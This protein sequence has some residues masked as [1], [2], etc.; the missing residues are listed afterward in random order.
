MSHQVYPVLSK[1]KGYTMFML[2]IMFKVYT[3]IVMY[4]MNFKNMMSITIMVCIRSM[5]YMTHA[6][7][8]CVSLAFCSSEEH[9]CC[10]G[11][12]SSPKG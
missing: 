6:V 10:P 4:I 3:V 12:G 11:V 9:I 1:S 8:C 7:D 5:M 2:Y